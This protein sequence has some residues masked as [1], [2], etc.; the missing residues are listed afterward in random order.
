MLLLL[1]CK[2]NMEQLINDEINNLR[3]TNTERLRITAAR[4][5]EIDEELLENMDRSDL[6]QVVAECKVK[7]REAQRDAAEHHLSESQVQLELKRMELKR[8]EFEIENQKRQRDH[9]YRMAQ[10]AGYGQEEG[11]AVGRIE[12]EGLVGRPRGRAETLADR[13]KRYGSALKQVMTRMSNES[14]EIPQFFESLEA[15]YAAFEIPTDLGLYAKLLLPFLSAKVRTLIARLTVKE[16]DDYEGLK[17]FILSESKLRP[18]EYKVRFDMATKLSDESYVYFVAR[19]RNNLRYY[20]R[21]REVNND[22]SRLADLLL[23]DR[24]KA[25]MPTAP[26]NYV[27][28]LEGSN[29][30][31]PK[32]VAELAV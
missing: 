20:L 5:G 32:K 19:L 13:V 12:G 24:L 22:F 11:K 8:L 1:V 4:T 29:W 23:A 28:S 17:D 10:V 30:F 25:V 27:L 18:R 26:L 9:K 3:K 21:S 31:D 7:S 15:V 16:L 2:I 14:S 6:L